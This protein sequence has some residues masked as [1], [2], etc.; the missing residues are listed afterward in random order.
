ME[1]KKMSTDIDLSVKNNF[2]C[3]EGNTVGQG[4]REGW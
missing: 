3:K 2:E 1:Q 4:E